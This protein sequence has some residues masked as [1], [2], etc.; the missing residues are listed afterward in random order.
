MATWMPEDTAADV[1]GLL[2]SSPLKLVLFSTVP[3]PAGAATD[4]VEAA[5]TR[6]PV[7]FSTVTDA[8]GARIMQATSSDA[9]TFAGMLVGSSEV[10]GFGLADAT[11]GEIKLV[12]D[13]WRPVRDFS[14]GDPFTVNPG[15]IVMHGARV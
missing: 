1:L 3:T 11:T 5:P 6:E 10:V 9:Q 13:S 2:L 12:N 15:Q 14:A 4:G 8:T 7:S